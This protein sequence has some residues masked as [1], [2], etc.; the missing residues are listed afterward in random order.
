MQ[1]NKAQQEAICFHNGPCLTLAGPGSGKTAVITQR[2]Y[3]LIHQWKVDPFHIL[4]VTFTRAAARE[5]RERFLRLEGQES[6]RVTFGTFHA[7]FFTILKHAYGY[8]ADNILREDEKLALMKQLIRRFHVD[9][10]DEAE[11]ISL[12][13]AEISSVKN[14]HIDIAHYYSANVGEQVFRDIY[15]AYQKE[16]SRSWRIDFDDM[17]VYT[18]ELFAQRKD[19]LSQ[20]Q[21]KYQYILVDEF[22]DINSIQYEIVKMLAAPRNNLFIVG[23]DDQSIYRFR[24]ARPEIMLNFVRDY[25]KASQILLDINYRCDAN[26]VAAAGRV[27]AHNQNRFPK[28]IRAE[29]GAQAAVVR[30]VYKNQREENLGLLQALQAYFAS[31]GQPGDVAV[32]F[33]TN[34]QP[35]LLMQQLMEYNIPFQTRDR[36]PNIYDHWIMKDLEAYIRI[37]GGSN[38][39]SDFLQIMNRP[40]RYIGRDSLEEE[41]V[42]FDVWADYYSKMEQE[43][44]ARRIDKLNYDCNM[45]AR[46][47][48]FSAVNYIRRG[49]GYEEYLTEYAKKRNINPED[50]LDVLEQLTEL[51]KGFESFRDWERHRTEYR[52]ELRAAAEAQRQKK[53]GVVLSTLHSSKGLEFDIVF[54]IDVNEGV[55]PYKKALLQAELEEERRM[56]YVGMTRAKKQLYLFSVEQM[57]NHGVEPSRFLKEMEDQPFIS[58]KY[59]S[60]SHSSKR[61]A[62][63]SCSSSETMFS[64]DGLPSSS[65][66]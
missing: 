14:S 62:A 57:G 31:G 5:M 60:S 40:N 4:V 66:K 49:I 23:D 53:E 22:Q 29:R 35:R 1:W 21:E 51:S 10:E 32:L 28:D 17:L 37:A 18:Y 58:S 46:M 55:M 2:T 38:A 6:T 25:P 52:E 39:R 63:A 48:P 44:I 34:T 30:K 3:H 50:L 43:W 56:F 19:I 12:L 20:W 24:Q 59:A 36:L 27:I 45:L 16:L 33:R 7:V 8:S 65:S 41:T 15:R 11:C 26:I 47:N 9:Y 64:R 61:S 13:L 42:A 54:L